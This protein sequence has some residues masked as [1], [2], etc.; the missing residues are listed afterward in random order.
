MKSHF[1]AMVFTALMIPLSLMAQG[2]IT[3]LVTDTDGNTLRGANV[4][5][6][7]TNLGDATDVDGNFSITGVPSGENVIVVDFIGFERAQ[8]TVFV[9]DGGTVSVEFILAVDVLA[10]A[11]I[12]VVGYGTQLRREITGS[13]ATISIDAF[14]DMPMLSFEN[15]IQGLISGVD[16]QEHSGEPGAAP[17]I[18]IRGAGSISA[19]ND[20]LYV[21]DGLPISKNLGAQGSLF[22]RRTAFKPPAS[23]PLA[24]INPNDIESIQILKDASAAAIYGSRGS[25]GVVIIT[26]K[27][28]KEGAKTTLR[29]DTYS[30]IQE[31]AHS[32]DMM[33]AEE[34]IAYTQ[35]ARNNNYI[36]TYDP[37]N[38]SSSYYNADYDPTTNVGRVDADG[39]AVSGSSLIP[40]KYVDWDGTDTDWLSLIFNPAPI[41]NYNLSVS[42]SGGG[43]NY[44]LSGGYLNQ[45]G[46]ID[47]SQFQRYTLSARLRGDVNKYV[48]FGVNLNSAFTN[49]N[50]V[51]ANAPYFGRPPGIVYSAMV[52]S[53]VIKPYND[54]GTPNQL[55]GQSY[56][57]NGT[58]SAS[59][60]L[61]IID[62]IDE[63]VDN[64]RTYGIV[65]TDIELIKGLVIRSSAGLDLSNYQGSFYRA[66]SL[67]YRTAK[68]GDPFASSTASRTFNW[69]WENTANYKVSLNDNHNLTVLAGYTAQKEVF[70]QNSVIASN[71]SDDQI[72]TLSGGQVTNGN[73]IKEEW[74]L[75]SLLARVNYNFKYKYLFTF[76][77][78]SDRSSRF[79][80]ANQTGVF[81]SFSAAWRASEES[82]IKGISAISEL[83]IRASYGV[84]GN[85]LIPNYGAI[86]LLGQG[87]YIID[88]QPVNAV[89]PST[90]SNEN[91]SWETTKQS[92]FGVDF[93]FF[94]NRL[95]GTFD[96]YTSIT[97]DLLM[98]VGVQSALGFTTALTNIGKVKNTGMELAIT[99]R[100]FVGAFQWATDFNYSTYKNEVLE[101]GP[102]DEPI[103]ASGSAG[104]RHITRV[105]DAIGSYFG[106]VVEGVYKDDA[107][108]A[109]SP[110]DKLANA[111]RPGDFKFKDVNGDGVIDSDDRTVTGSYH[112]DFT[113]GVT[114]R[115]NFGS[116]DLSIF[117]Q[118]VEGREILNLTARHMKNGE[119]NF[120]SYAI[121]NERWRSEAE[122]GNGSIPRADR[123]TSA[124]GNNNRPS[125]FQVEDGSYM[126]L[127]T[128]TIGYTLPK[129][130]T[131]KFAQS[132]RVYASGKN[133]IMW[134][135]YIGFNPEVS[136]QSQSML[137][138]G[139]DYG[140][141]PL[142]KTWIFGLSTTF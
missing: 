36:Q 71:F 15:A 8:Q 11:E 83:K 109:A 90:I 98:E 133:L 6:E 124:H 126:R 44:Y 1:K 12:V 114:N 112:P 66:N 32:V 27:Q 108:I 31:V 16:I 42:G 19:G 57:G 115:F 92:D 88:D 24:S 131:S 9:P 106:Y 48:R 62:A 30:G 5:V 51:P 39:N 73:S 54:D 79:G 45:E 125:S 46:I 107:D 82:F 110:E 28:A 67:L 64:H 41:S 117:F 55:D 53:P 136:L 113:Y 72:Q 94:N 69:L 17:N 38:P 2:T 58:T 25:N 119:A 132:I 63:L 43:L 120:N 121:E 81:P 85:F 105:G 50:R 21:I 56:L 118:G 68:T 84:T 97:E 137:V 40:E 33:N 22:R 26:T 29:F 49:H 104:V 141:Y 102:G 59:N 77:V 74:S 60:P 37:L 103:M 101:L 87:L 18:R 96:V 86:G 129:S 99:S 138:Q 65:Y 135:D 4:L 80:V 95:Y 130:F 100:N 34:V 70:D 89:Y 91:L 7:G 140:A 3:G 142:A 123:S 13:V 47:N 52:H 93:G 139:E 76:A 122:P 75:V 23:N 127:K 111:P 134:T 116:F 128:L 14:R 61:A 10:G 78:R 20:P 35:D